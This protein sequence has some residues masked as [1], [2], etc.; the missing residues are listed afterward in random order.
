[1]G[2]GAKPLALSFHPRPEALNIDPKPADIALLCGQAGFEYSAGAARYRDDRFGLQG[3]K[4]DASTRSP[5]G[6]TR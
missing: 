2:Q 1:L 4:A 6:A 5:Q 3:V